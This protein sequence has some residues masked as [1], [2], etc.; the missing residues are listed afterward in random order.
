[1]QLPLLHSGLAVRG[2]LRRRRLTAWFDAMETR[3]PAYSARVQGA[4]ASWAA[5]LSTAG[6]GNSYA[7]RQPQQAVAV[8]SPTDDSAVAQ[9]GA[10]HHLRP[11]CLQCS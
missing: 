4:P 3:V 7:P 5:V 9:V 11:D 6:F 2:D 8:H 10:S 1:V